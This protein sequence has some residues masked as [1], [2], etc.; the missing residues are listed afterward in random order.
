MLATDWSLAMIDAVRAEALPNLDARVMDGQRLNLPDA[1]FDP[2]F[3]LFGIMLFPNWRKGLAELVR[4]I[5]PG[6]LGCVGSW[7]HP[8]GAAAN[9]LLAQ[10]VAKLYPGFP[11][12]T[13]ADGPENLYNSERFIRAL[14]HAGLV[15]VVMHEV[16]QDYLLDPADLAQPDRLFQFSALWRS[17]D[18]IMREQVIQ[19]I[20]TAVSQ[21]P[22]T[23]SVR[24]PAWIAIGHRET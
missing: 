4:V 3:S 9:L 21:E 15:N 5:R 14:T 12:P 8:A 10:H 13:V 16:I 22:V 6:G 17:I 18:G 23:L 24:S 7:Q 20:E 1:S 11:V 2:A 19:S